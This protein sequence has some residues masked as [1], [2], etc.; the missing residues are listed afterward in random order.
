[1]KFRYVL[2][3]LLGLFISLSAITGK[4]AIEGSKYRVLILPFNI[5]SEKDLTFLQKGI[6][7]MLSTRI[8]AS[9]SAVLVSGDEAVAAFKE[10]DAAVD[11][12][13]AISMGKKFS[14]DYVLFGSLTVFGESISTDARFVNVA[15]GQEMVTFSQT[16][17]THGDVISHVNVL[18]SQV[19]EKGFGAVRIVT[20]PPAPVAEESTI[21][22]HPDKLLAPSK[23]QPTVLSPSQPAVL[24][25]APA[26][27]LS[28]TPL[29][30]GPRPA[31]APTMTYHQALAYRAAPVVPATAWRSGKL[32]IKITGLG[33]DDVDGDGQNE[34]VFVSSS[35]IYIYRYTGGK[36]YKLKEIIGKKSNNYIGLDIAD[37]N[38][39][40]LPEIFVTQVSRPGNK[41]N[42]KGS[43]TGYLK[44]FVLEWN[45]SEFARI[46]DRVPWFLRVI[47]MPG[48]GLVLLGQKRD[49]DKV[50]SGRVQQLVWK[51]AGYEPESALRL[52][53]GINIYGFAYGDVQNNGT[54]M[55]AAFSNHDRIILLDENWDEEWISDERYGGSPTYIEYPRAYDAEEADRYYVPP[56]IHVVDL[57]MDGRQEIIAVKNVDKAKR[58]LS[59]FRLFKNGYIECLEWNNIGLEI[60]W[61]TQKVSR[62]I[63]DYVIGDMNNDGQEEVVFSVVTT[64]GTIFKKDRS[65]IVSWKPPTSMPVAAQ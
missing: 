2:S 25:S 45:G 46:V 43:W 56:R 38:G 51:G 5:H 44:S 19:N 12:P 47:N 50:F 21:G 22:Q 16:G 59:N 7:D 32:D 15:A 30:P 17:S 60:K 1:M 35:N 28:S 49:R 52:P 4:T 53:E 54:Q 23:N 62:H 40:G 8:A 24:P 61:Q 11:M 18:A 57:D 6:R 65:Y 26:D 63:S 10:M 20:A 58:A 3:L 13:A 48:K 34:T 31:P 64:A 27:V 37:I 36:Y 39:N 42:K 9:G 29:S 55:I 14:A 33:V 41:E